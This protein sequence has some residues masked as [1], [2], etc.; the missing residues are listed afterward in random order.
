[1]AGW[2]RETRA[3][4][5]SWAIQLGRSVLNYC[6]ARGDLGLVYGKVKGENDHL[7]GLRTCQD[8]RRRW[9]SLLTRRSWSGMRSL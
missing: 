8:V 9:R 4:N 7:D 5:P 6:N 1:M 2:S 3:K